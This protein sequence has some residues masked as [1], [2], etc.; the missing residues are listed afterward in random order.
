MQEWLSSKVSMQLLD[1]RETYERQVFDIGGIHIPYSKFTLEDVKVFDPSVPLVVYCQHGVRS[2][3][4]AN[5]F[6]GAGFEHVFSL[7]GGIHAWLEEGRN[8]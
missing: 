1:V 8:L 3:H 2:D 5:V 6:V 4:I 7:S